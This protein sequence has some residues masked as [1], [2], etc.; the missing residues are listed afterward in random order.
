MWVFVIPVI[1]FASLTF[2]GGMAAPAEN[3]PEQPPAPTSQA[4]PDGGPKR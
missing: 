4:L 1:I 2:A 3:Q